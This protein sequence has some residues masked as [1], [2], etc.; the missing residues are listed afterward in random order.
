MFVVCDGEDLSTPDL[1]RRHGR[2]MHRPA[3]L[4]PVPPAL[5]RASAALLGRQAALERLCG[6][7][8]IDNR[9]ACE[10]LGWRPPIDVDEGLR[11]TVQ[12]MER[13]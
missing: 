11:R 13:R 1:V 3:R 10:L 5:L 8:Q 4:L 2:A 7:L 12:G 6:N 9:K